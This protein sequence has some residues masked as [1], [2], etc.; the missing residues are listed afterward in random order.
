VITSPPAPCWV[1]LPE[2]LTVYLIRK[3]LPNKLLTQFPKLLGIL[4]PTGMGSQWL[5]PDRAVRDEG[6]RVIYSRIRENLEVISSG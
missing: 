5:I 6:A 3:L 2:L 4:L 1:T